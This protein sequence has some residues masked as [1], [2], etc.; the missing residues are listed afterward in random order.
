MLQRFGGS[1]SRGEAPENFTFENTTTLVTSGIYHYIR[2]PMYSSLLLL[3]WG[4]FFKHLSLLGLL[5]TILTTILTVI[6]G[7]I[8]EKENL[9]FFGPDYI[10]YK[11]TSK[12]FLP[13]L[14]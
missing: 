13:F 10:E 7:H 11:K 12:M 5:I 4:A 1:K 9:V 8:E 14:F 6:L 2:H 3:A